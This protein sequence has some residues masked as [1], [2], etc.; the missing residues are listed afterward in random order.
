MKKFI[1]SILVLLVIGVGFYIGYRH[2]VNKK[3]ELLNTFFTAIKNRDETQI[4]SLLRKGMNVNAKDK[5]GTT[6]LMRIAFDGNTS[7]AKYLL[8]NGADVNLSNNF[9]MTALMNAA[10]RPYSDSHPKDNNLEIARILVDHGA[11]INFK[12]KTGWTALMGAANANQTDVALYLLDHG[13]EVNTQYIP[14]GQTVLI[15]A[16]QRRNK[17]LVEAL[18]NKGADVN[19]RDNSGW[20]VLRQAQDHPEITELLKQAG[21]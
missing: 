8:D 10:S 11:D 1:I 18:I 4:Q 2:S 19:I 7:T 5:N 15:M 17:V 21:A 16:V 12:S 9:E 13:A 20:S 6:P 14:N 3:A